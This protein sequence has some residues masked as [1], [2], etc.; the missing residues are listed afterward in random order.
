MRLKLHFLIF[1]ALSGLTACSS[2][3]RKFNIIGNIAGMPE[4][5][6]VLEQ[7]NA[8]DIITIVDSERSKPDGHF[9]LSGISP[10]QGLYRLH[11]HPGK[12]ILL[13]IDKGNIKVT[14]DWN[15]FE[16]YTVTGSAASE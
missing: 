15:S 9:E 8:N 13:S 4:Q 14:G 11:F 16:N 7:L 2:S 5:T 10:E 6:I 3:N 12:F 1:I